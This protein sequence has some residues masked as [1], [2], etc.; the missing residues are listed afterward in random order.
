M[1]RNGTC[2]DLM[3]HNKKWRAVKDWQKAA[4]DLSYNECMS[5][6]CLRTAESIRLEMLVGEPVR[7]EDF[8]PFF[9]KRGVL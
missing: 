1:I 3:S 2:D 9:E 5:R 4:R 7:P 8:R 6:V